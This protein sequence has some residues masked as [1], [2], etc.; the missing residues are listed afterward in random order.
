MPEIN[1]AFWR[2]L[3]HHAG[4]ERAKRIEHMAKGRFAGSHE[5]YVRA[6]GFTE[7]LDWVLEEANRIL[8][9]EEDDDGESA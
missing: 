2:T 7:G 1:T 9:S 8:K 3:L 4:V 6:V 5:G